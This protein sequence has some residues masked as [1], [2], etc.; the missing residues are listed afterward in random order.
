MIVSSCV[1]VTLWIHLNEYAI[2]LRFEDNS[3]LQ[4]A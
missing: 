1:N 3:C 2:E 4:K